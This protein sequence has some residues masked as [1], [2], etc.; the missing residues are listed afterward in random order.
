MN[1]EELISELED[2]KEEYG[3]L[4]VSDGVSLYGIDK[5]VRVRIVEALGDIKKDVMTW[6]AEK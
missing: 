4:E 1:I 5:G 3:N 2:V 6:E